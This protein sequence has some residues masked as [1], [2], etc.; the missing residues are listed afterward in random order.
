MNVC[1]TSPLR[2]ST[3]VGILAI[4]NRFGNL[5]TLLT[6]TVQNKTDGCATASLRIRGRR[7]LHLRHHSAMKS[8]HTNGCV[9]TRSSN[10]SGV[11]TSTSWPFFAVA[12]S[13]DENGLVGGG[14]A[15]T[16]ATGVCRTAGDVAVYDGRVLWMCGLADWGETDGE[17]C[18]DVVVG[19]ASGVTK[20][21]EVGEEVGSVMMVV[22]LF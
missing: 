15:A 19:S 22:R 4:S 3:K 17:V 12:S 13:S 18:A 16:V 5:A 8:T 6:S 7:Y 9:A 2:S 11:L 1:T 10:C 20:V 21:N 14:G